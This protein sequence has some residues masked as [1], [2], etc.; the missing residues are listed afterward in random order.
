[1]D[2]L[3]DNPETD[4]LFQ[5][6]LVRV[7]RLKNGEAAAQMKAMGVRYR[8]NWGA[9]VVS[10]R[11][12]ARQYDK[13]HLL[14]LK[15]WN[16]QWRETMILATLFEQP[17]FLSEEQMDYWTKSFETAEMAEQAVANLFVHSKF[18]FAKALEYCCGKKHWV[19]YSGILLMGKL[20]L[21]DK[22]AIDE[23]FGGFF[24]VIYP[25]MKDP[26]LNAAL[27]RSM[28]ILG[29]R[30]ENLR[31]QCI[32]FLNTVLTKGDDQPKQLA[33]ILLDEFR[34]STE[35]DSENVEPK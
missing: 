13:S 34:D 1:M 16:K 8:V 35:L 22:H 3:L 20:A 33:T 25:L 24:E 9:S 10:L 31:H 26:A 4:Q 27:Y 29:N 18:A 21:A 30:N 6:L 5:E 17:K 28:V 2:I 32:E 19:R 7:R 12:L 11:E 15:L 23:M 14:A